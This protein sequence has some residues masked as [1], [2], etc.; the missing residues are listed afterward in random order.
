MGFWGY[1]V[2]GRSDGS[3]DAL[4]ALADVR[5]GLVLHEERRDGWQVWRRPSDPDAEAGDMGALARGVTEETGLPALFA[6]V[7]GGE[8]VVVE[9][10]APVGGSWFGCLGREAM[11]RYLG[12]DGLVVED[13]F[14]GARDAAAR[15]V[16]WACEAGTVAQEAALLAVL[17]EQVGLSATE[18]LD[19]FLDRLGLARL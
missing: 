5:D 13:L 11:A 8:C 19:T 4:D 16:E 3:L 1:Y 9:A 6:F 18:L 12:A 2:V 7:M 14:L 17:E 10:A 15:A